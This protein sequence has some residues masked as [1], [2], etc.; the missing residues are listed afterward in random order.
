MR[1]QRFT[2]WHALNFA[3]QFTF[4]ALILHFWSINAWLY[5]VFSSFFAGSLHPCAAHFIAEHYVFENM[6]QETFSYYGPLNFLTYNV[7]EACLMLSNFL[8]LRIP[9]LVT[10]S[11]SKVANPLTAP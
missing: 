1:S 11:K 8:N 10:I 2:I 3:V 4:I 7:S 5:L 6:G 9:R